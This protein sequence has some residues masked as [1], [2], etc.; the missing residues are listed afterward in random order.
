MTTPY[1]RFK[2]QNGFLKC[3]HDK[4]GE[5]F[6]IVKVQKKRVH[7]SHEELREMV[8]LMDLYMFDYNQGLIK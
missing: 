6:I 1:A 7:L 5:F 8:G 4:A 3:G 2:S